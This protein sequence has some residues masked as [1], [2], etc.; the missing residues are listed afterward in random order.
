MFQQFKNKTVQK[1][2]LNL[3]KN[4]HSKAVKALDSIGIIVDFGVLEDNGNV[5]DIIQAFKT[6]SNTVQVIAVSTGK[7]KNQNFDGLVLMNNQMTWQ[8]DFKK[9]TDAEKFQQNSYDLL[10]NYFEES[11]PQMRLLSA[12][13]QANLKVGF[14]TRTDGINDL[15]IDVK[16]TKISKFADEVKKYLPLINQ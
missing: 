13:V 4:H 14:P 6:K 7:L 1:K 2:F 3:Q 12:S 8:G 11:T 16:P 9:E 5:E 10:I 15:T